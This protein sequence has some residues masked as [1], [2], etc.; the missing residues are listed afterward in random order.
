M[1]FT[2]MWV[3]VIAI[4]NLLLA[5]GGFLLWRRHRSVATLLIGVGFTAALLALAISLFESIE[6]TSFSRSHSDA[7]FIIPHPHLLTVAIHWAGLV[8]LW[9]AAVGMLWHAVRDR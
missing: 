9:T 7:S 3:L 6:Y 4:P 8:G 2:L 1:A 5:V